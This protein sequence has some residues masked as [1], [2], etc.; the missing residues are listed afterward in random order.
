L[1]SELDHIKGIGP[2]SA[3]QLLQELK[4]VKKI[5]EAKLETLIDMLGNAKG[6]LVYEHFHS[7][8]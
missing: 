5:K 6:S 2:E 3:K 7:S 8:K 4:S 1:E